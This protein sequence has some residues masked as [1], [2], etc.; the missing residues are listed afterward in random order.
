ME[1]TNL[2]KETVDIIQNLQKEIEG[3]KHLK[4]N[5]EV[6]WRL[7]WMINN[8]LL[9]DSANAIKKSLAEKHGIVL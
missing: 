2:T 7:E 3:L 1:N 5:V 4:S 8:K 9:Q 6:S